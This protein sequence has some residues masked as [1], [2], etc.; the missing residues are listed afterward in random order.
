MDE[1]TRSCADCG[2]DITTRHGNAT[3]CQPCAGE[4]A[5]WQQGKG[6]PGACAV[7][8]IE[9]VSSRLRRG[10]CETHYR[11]LMQTGTTDAPIRID[12]LTHF[13]VTSSGCWQWVGGM[14][15]NGYGKT[16]TPVNGTRLAH[17]A[18]Y[19]EHVAPI[20]DGLDLDHLCR[21]RACCNPAHLEPVTRSVNIQ[22]GVDARLRGRCNQGHE[23]TGG[24][25]WVEPSTG[26]RY[27]K[28]C[29]R[30]REKRNRERRQAAS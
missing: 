20:D 16:S 25:V 21:N 1:S 12:N 24:N 17:R 28:P 22:R 13:T 9:C 2:A 4:R 10:M 18:F 26:S 6:K 30:A 29:K 27:C 8:T 11:R 7:D 23:Q 19:I 5:K 14:W 15:P 3:R